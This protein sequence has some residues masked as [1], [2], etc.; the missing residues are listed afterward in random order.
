MRTL[1]PLSTATICA[2]TGSPRFEVPSRRTHV[3]RESP[4]AQMLSTRRGLVPGNRAAKPSIACFTSSSDA[5][6]TIASTA[7]SSPHDHERTSLSSA[8]SAQWLSGSPLVVGAP[9][10]GAVAPQPT[11]T[12]PIAMRP[13]LR[14][15]VLV[16]TERRH[17]PLSR[18]SPR[19]AS[20][21]EVRLREDPPN[22]GALGLDELLDFV[23][24]ADHVVRRESVLHP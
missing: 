19:C 1:G 20:G 18:G 9:V 6:A 22:L 10:V 8:V 3:C 5:D 12:L 11:K 15:A 17:S 7:V 4:T 2:S 24:P 21:L 13:V 14:T 23:D 16:Q